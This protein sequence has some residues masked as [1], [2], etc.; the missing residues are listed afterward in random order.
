MIKKYH[1]KEYDE[2]PYNIV[3]AEAGEC[4]CNK[5]HSEGDPVA[6][7]IKDPREYHLLETVQ[8]MHSLRVKV[9]DDI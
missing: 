5:T 3:T 9:E 6:A 8:N 7:S 1:T 2:F 4:K